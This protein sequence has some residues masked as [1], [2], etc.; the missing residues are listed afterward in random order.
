[1]SGVERKIDKLGRIVLPIE[2]RKRL[3]LIENSKVTVSINNDIIFIT[4]SEQKCLICGS[5]SHLSKTLP[6]CL[7]CINKIKNEA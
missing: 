7:N 4:P 5:L 3:C 2:Y 1:M 6:L